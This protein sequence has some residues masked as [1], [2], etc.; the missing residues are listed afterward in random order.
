MN[1]Y[2]SL[3][4]QQRI[5]QNGSEHCTCM[6]GSYIELWE[7]VAHATILPNDGEPQDFSRGTQKNRQYVTSMHSN[8]LKKGNFLIEDIFLNILPSESNR[9][10]FTLQHTNTS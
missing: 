4:F 10:F 9:H 1:N 6:Y 2:A 8:G 7:M 3:N 5:C